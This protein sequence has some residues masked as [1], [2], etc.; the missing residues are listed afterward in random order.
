LSE[1]GPTVIAMSDQFDFYVGTW[2]VHNRRLAK[3]LVGSTEWEEFRGVS[4][5]R[6]IFGGAG[7]MDEIDFPTKGWSGLTIR[8][9][10]P[11]HD[12]W[13]LFWISSR[14]HTIEPPV[15]GRWDEKR[16]FVGYCDDVYEGTPIRV[17][18]TWSNISATTAR[19]EQAFSTD[20]G[21]TWETNWTMESQRTA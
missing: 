17:R 19:W 15:V 3:A 1:V 16:E 18:F 5:A 21:E 9:Y 8:L 2:E 6:P 13:S 12:Q 11:E 14:G 7:N 4:V 20:G 10:D